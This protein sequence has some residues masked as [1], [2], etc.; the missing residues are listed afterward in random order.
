MAQH[1]TL[2]SADPR[3][4]SACTLDGANTWRHFAMYGDQ[5]GAPIVADNSQGVSFTD[6]RHGG[7]LPGK[8][9]G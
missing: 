1:A 2:F 7:C 3:S 4:F 5:S 8:E 9:S 6:L